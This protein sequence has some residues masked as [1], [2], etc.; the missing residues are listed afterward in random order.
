M[1][2]T[3]PSTR[4]TGELITAAIWN[5]DIT[6][7]LTYL[8]LRPS[9]TSLINEAS[10]YST[11]ATT[12]TDVDSTDAAATVTTNGG[13]VLVG[14]TGT[15]K[16]GGNGANFDVDVDGARQGGDSGLISVAVPTDGT[17]TDR[18]TNASFL[19][20]VTGLAAGSHTFK[21]QWRV[22]DGTATLWAG[23]GSGNAK[24]LH[25]FFFVKEI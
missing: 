17:Y 9:D 2:W 3:S 12:F 10:N 21:L 14:F 6:D 11:S 1:G 15:V 5:S 18:S 23:A 7:N 20:L 13:D 25:P 24:D 4:V 22:A 19:L 8:N 16:A